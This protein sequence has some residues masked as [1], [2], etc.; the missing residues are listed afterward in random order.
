[1]D[2]GVHRACRFLFRRDLERRSRRLR[3]GAREPGHRRPDRQARRSRPAARGRSLVLLRIAIRR[4]SGHDETAERG[5]LPARDAEAAPA[6]AAAYFDLA[7]YYREAGNADR[8]LIEYGHVL[9]LDPG[10]GAAHDRTAELL[11]SAGRHDDAVNEWRLALQALNNRRAR[12]PA[13]PGFQEDVRAVLTHLG[14]H[15]VLA[16]V[17]ADTDR[18]LKT[19][20]RRNGTYQFEPLVQGILAAA[21]DAQRGVAWL[22]ELSRSAGDPQNV[23]SFA[24]RSDSVSSAQR[25][26]LYQVLVDAEQAKAASSF[27]QPRE[28]PKPDCARGSWIGCGR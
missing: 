15:E 16:Q 7:D 1:M 8:A 17:R 19:Y 21:G 23:L 20:L 28:T 4:V 2:V 5:G 18:L 9:Q 6:N 24:V 22:T 25:D 3:A 26:A 13:P 27:G 12:G 14:Q 11:W 10:R